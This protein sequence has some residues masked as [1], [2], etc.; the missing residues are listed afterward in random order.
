MDIS[1]AAM[2]FLAIVN[3]A[4]VNI[5]VHVSL[6]IRIFSGYMPR[7]GIVGAYGDYSFL[8]DSHTVFHSGC[9]KVFYFFLLNKYFIMN[10][11]KAI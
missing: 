5:G 3:S 8:R 9:T 2:S 10:L 6:H 1:V 11:I 7:S 4:A